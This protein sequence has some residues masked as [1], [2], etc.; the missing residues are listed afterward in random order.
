MSD[1]P[2]L[3]KQRSSK[4]KPSQRARE[5]AAEVTVPPQGEPEEAPSALAAKIKTKAKRAKPK[6]QL[7]FGGADEEVR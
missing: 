6:T 5:D 4:A 1:K 7:S 3:F 2:P